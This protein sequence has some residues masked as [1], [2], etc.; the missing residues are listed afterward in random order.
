MAGYFGYVLLIAFPV[1]FALFIWVISLGTLIGQYWQRKVLSLRHIHLLLIPLITLTFY[2][3]FQVAISYYTVFGGE[4]AAARKCLAIFMA[5]VVFP[6]AGLLLYRRHQTARPQKYE[7]G[8]AVPLFRQRDGISCAIA[9]AAIGLVLTTLVFVAESGARRMLVHAAKTNNIELVKLLTGVGA[10]VNVKGKLHHSPLWFACRNG[11]LEMVN[12]LLANG[13]DLEFSSP[14]S[15]LDI[16]S[17]HCRTEIVRLLL[18]RGIDVNL[19][20]PYGQTALMAA[21]R[22]GALDVAKILVEH[23]ADV[24]AATTHGATALLYACDHSAIS[25]AKLLLENGANPEVKATYGDSPMLI[26]MRRRNAE[27]ARLLKSYG[28]KD[29]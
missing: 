4:A 7:T 11:N 6:Y 20:D 1:L 17:Y 13:A 8:D 15:L 27:L 10:D 21:S 16:A 29:L 25:L 12:L 14:Q 18:N 22:G 28:A 19:K 26:A 2:F 3:C 9:A 5:V 24:N 23:G